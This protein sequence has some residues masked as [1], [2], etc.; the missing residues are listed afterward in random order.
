MSTDS[1]EPAK[2]RDEGCEMRIQGLLDENL[3]LAQ[4]RQEQLTL[5]NLGSYLKSALSTPEVYAAIEC[6]GPHIWPEAT[7]AV[8]L[9]HANGDYLER[10]ASWG[11]ASL[12]KQSLAWQDCWAL[13][14]SQPH[15]IRDTGN[16]LL[17]GHI[18]Q[19]S[20]TLPSLCMPLIAH[21]RMLGL[22][23]LQR[24]KNVPINVAADPGL[25]LAMAVAEDLC[26]ALANMRL[27][28]SLREQS[29]R[30]PLTGLFNRRF[31]DEYLV[32]ELARAQRMK[33]Q[34]SMVALDIDHFKRINDTF[35]HSAGDVVLKKVSTVLRAHVR[36]SD[37]A[38]R[39]GGE[40]FLLLLAE[41][42]LRFAAQRAEDIRGA[43]Y[44]MP[45]WYEEKNL[46]QITASFGAAAY[47]DHGSTADALFRA[48]DE[49]LYSAKHAG[50]NQVVSAPPPA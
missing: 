40:E 15:C 4:F 28:E 21:G 27:R 16:G 1:G 24:L 22:L 47:P 34:I 26:L 23:H 18:A 44:E 14:R 48:A 39:I 50:R 3:E 42:P 11:D 43:I 41:S 5:R 7:G 12:N 32:Q 30:D 2:P 33:R 35:G 31:V 46:G 49:A 45:M 38:S 10:V 37:I 29:I 13:R 19:D 8:Y 25:A 36:G 20:G 17:C 6:F 9:L